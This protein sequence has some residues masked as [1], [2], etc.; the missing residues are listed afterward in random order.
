MLGNLP[1][2]V[3]EAAVGFVALHTLTV[4]IYVLIVLT[5]VAIIG[6]HSQP[7]GIFGLQDVIALNGIGN[8]YLTRLDIDLDDR[9]DFLPTGGLLHALKELGLQLAGQLVVGV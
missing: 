2:L 8:T 1:L 6:E 5:I 7:S 3:I 9:S 4:A